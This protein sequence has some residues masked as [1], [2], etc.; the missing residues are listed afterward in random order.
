MRGGERS[1]ASEHHAEAVGRKHR[2][3]GVATLEFISTSRGSLWPWLVAI[4]TLQ[5]EH[6]TQTLFIREYTFSS[7]VYDSEGGQTS[8]WYKLGFLSAKLRL[9]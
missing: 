2:Q 1:N 5:A 8:T 4:I 9:D 6:Q 3:G 7:T